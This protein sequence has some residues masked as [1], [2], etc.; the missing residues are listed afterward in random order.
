MQMVMDILFLGWSLLNVQ[1]RHELPFNR[2]DTI[3]RSPERY[4]TVSSIH[5]LKKSGPY[6]T[7]FRNPIASG[8]CYASIIDLIYLFQIA[9]FQLANFWLHYL[10]PTI[11][12]FFLAEVDHVP[13]LLVNS[14]LV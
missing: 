13:K 1:H 7:V 11:V 9:D 6:K 4:R 8:Q 5:R 2:I 10:L 12:F 14:L 3:V